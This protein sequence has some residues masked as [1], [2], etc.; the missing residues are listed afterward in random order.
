MDI[1]LL[2]H[3]KLDGVGPVDNR[4]SINLMAKFRRRRKNKNKIQWIPPTEVGRG[5]KKMSK[6]DN[7]EAVCRTAPATPGLV[8]I[9]SILFEQS[10]QN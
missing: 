10:V 6:S 1:I 3:F 9:R 8:M 4:P 2:I 7:L 5:R